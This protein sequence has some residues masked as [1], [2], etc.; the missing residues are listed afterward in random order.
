M[1][2]ALM[3]RTVYAHND[4]LAG[5]VLLLDADGTG[6]RRVQLIDYEY[7]GYNY[8]GYDL[9][10]HFCEYAGFDGDFG[11]YSKNLAREQALTEA[12]NKEHPLAAFAGT[13][14]A[15]HHQFDAVV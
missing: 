4:L 11:E 3:L 12:A 9:A 7:A 2:A 14:D 15:F 6:R 1:C 13:P 8:C 10:N 5:N